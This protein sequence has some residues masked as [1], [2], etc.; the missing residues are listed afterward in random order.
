MTISYVELS[1]DI[2]Y[3][4]SDQVNETYFVAQL[5]VATP[6]NVALTAKG[7]TIAAK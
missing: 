7:R 5:C 4:D 1:T 3:P 2:S 6:L